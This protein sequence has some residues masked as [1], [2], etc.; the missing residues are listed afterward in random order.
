MSKNRHSMRYMLIAVLFCLVCVIYLGRLFYIQISG[1]ENTYDSGTTRRTVTLQAVRG[2][3]YDRNGR[4]LVSNRYTYD[5]TF[6]HEV[7]SQM[8]PALRNRVYLRSLQG[9]AACGESEKHEERF[10]P[11]EGSYPDYRLSAAAEDGD[12]VIYYRLQRVLTDLGLDEDGGDDSDA[13]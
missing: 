12:S 6:S 9:L 7:T 3:I 1:R 11:Y 5:L 2:E 4:A 10:F 8:T 13:E